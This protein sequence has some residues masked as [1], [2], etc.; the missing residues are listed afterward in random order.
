VQVSRRDRYIGIVAIAAIAAL[1]GLSLRTSTPLPSTAPASPIARLT[2]NPSTS[3]GPAVPVA[4]PTVFYSILGHGRETLY[5]RRL[6]GRSDPVELASYPAEDEGDVVFLVGPTRE[7]ILV[8]RSGD[9]QRILAPVDVTDPSG[10][11]PWRVE[12]PAMDFSFGVWSPDGAYWA[13][14]VSRGANHAFVLEASSGRTWSVPLGQG[15]VQGFEGNG[16][17]VVVR[18]ETRDPLV[19]PTLQIVDVATAE[20]RPIAGPPVD[21]PPHSSY[22]YDVA[23]RTGLWVAENYDSDELVIGD[24]RTGVTRPVDAAQSY[25]WFGFFPSGDRILLT[26]YSGEDDCGVTRYSVRVASL[27]NPTREVW[28]GTSSPHNVV[29]GAGGALVG[30]SG[31]G[32]TGSTMILIDLASGRS[33]ELP[34]PAKTWM[35][36]LLAIHGG[37]GLPDPALPP[38]VLEPSEPPDPA[39]ELVADA[40]WLVTGWVDYDAADCT[41]IARVR[42]VGPSTDGGFAV[43]DELPPAIFRDVA[44]HDVGVHVAPRPGTSTVLVAYGHRR[45]HRLFLWTP[46]PG[47]DPGTEPVIEPLTLP[48]DWPEDRSPGAWRPDG[49]AIGLGSTRTRSFLWFDLNE[50]VTH[51]TRVGN[52][53]AWNQVVGWTA[54]GSSILIERNGCID[55]CD[56]ERHWVG[57]LRL[58]DG[59]VRDLTLD[60]PIDAI[61]TGTRGVSVRT[62]LAAWSTG[63]NRITLSPGIG[64]PG[65]FTF[66]LPGRLRNLDG[67]TE[68]WSRD[69]R[70]LYVVA[71]TDRGRELVRIND[72]RPDSP[73]RFSAVGRLPDWA[74]VD[75]VEIAGSWV[76]VRVSRL[77]VCD[78]GLVN[79]ET[80]EAYLENGCTMSHAWLRS[81]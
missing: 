58:S 43:I 22:S 37:T 51:R 81:S 77:G 11:P 53:D 8:A 64:L 40:P 36:S 21:A 27:T 4:G 61:G 56:V 12:A 44:R 25:R 47:R 78:A 76:H 9:G 5:E 10:A 59:R 29:F 13:G 69:G 66:R 52:D 3:Q 19:G 49:M 17:N 38:A 32:D 18:R 1:A 26:A 62:G 63:A 48:S 50:Q 60:E 74:Y 72:P 35:G 80:G 23:P 57:V 28:A 34:R 65:D 42:L 39:L 67:R 20:V 54:D 33:I 79:L 71:E 2:P 7:A 15:W 68:L 46:E 16:P 31:W 30:F 41:A 73:L 24:L 75:E 55:Y 45:D 6:D 70:Q 14:F